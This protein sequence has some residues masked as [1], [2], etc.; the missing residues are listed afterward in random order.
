VVSPFFHHVGEADYYMREEPNMYI[1]P[2]VSLSEDTAPKGKPMSRRSR[3]MSRRVARTSQ[4]RTK[5]GAKPK[6]KV[7]LLFEGDPGYKTARKLP[8]T[9]VESA[10]A[11]KS[12]LL[13]NLSRGVLAQAKQRRAAFDLIGQSVKWSAGKK[14]YTGT[15]RSLDGTR[16][17]VQCDDGR[18]VNVHV[19]AVSSAASK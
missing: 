12:T 6:R 14:T 13:S 17:L 9:F 4:Q 1:F 15:L 8:K 10:I 3:M 7:K 19:S 5:V 11:R 2:T 16:A 18:S